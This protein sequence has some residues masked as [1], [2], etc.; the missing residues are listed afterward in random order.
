MTIAERKNIKINLTLANYF[1]FIL[2]SIKTLILFLSSINL[3]SEY[4]IVTINGK[5][6]TYVSM[7]NILFI[8]FS[9]TNTL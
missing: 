8:G 6:K 2:V 4:I 1:E 7:T 5:S 3:Q 9:S